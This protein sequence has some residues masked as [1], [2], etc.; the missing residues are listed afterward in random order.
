MNRLKKMISEQST[1]SP[2]TTPS[3]TNDHGAATMNRASR[4]RLQK[5]FSEY[6]PVPG[7]I[8]EQVDKNDFSHYKLTISPIDGIYV[9][10]KWEFSI[11]CPHDYP[12]NPP[13]VLCVTPI[14]H[15]NIDLQG[16]VC[17]SILRVD[18]DWSPVCT[19]NHVVQ[20]L[21]FLFL[22]P[23]PTD[24]LNNEAGDHM[25]KDPAGF[26]ALVHKTMRGG[27]FFGKNFP[28]FK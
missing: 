14:Y 19:L 2:G 16:H 9:G 12:N 23:N 3:P 28:R 26:V 7:C 13:K 27:K 1:P 17:L 25:S 11:E 15:P 24:P 22:E 5:D 6:E 20:G 21:L 18:K 8:F 4:A 10:G